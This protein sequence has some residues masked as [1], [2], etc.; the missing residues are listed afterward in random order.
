MKKYANIISIIIILG[1]VLFSPILTKPVLAQCVIPMVHGHNGH[2]EYPGN[3]DNTDIYKGWGL[4]IDQTSGLYNWIHYSIPVHLGTKVRYLVIQYKMGSIDVLISD[5]HVFR[6]GVKIYD[7]PDLDWNET[8][9]TYQIIDM[10]AEF[11]M[12]D[13]AL[14][15]TIKVGA[16]VEMMSHNVIIYSVGTSECL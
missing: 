7:S 14:G 2:V 11:T 4:D 8:V 3:L 16:G 1:F 6:G 13:G 15:L 9:A 5:I 10:G 12:S